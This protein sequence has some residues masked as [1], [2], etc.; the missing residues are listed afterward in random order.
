MAKTKLNVRDMTYVALG[1]ALM[2]IG[3]WITI[4]LAPPL[5]PFTLQ[6]FAVFT[7]LMTLGWRRGTYATLVYILL[8]AVG[9][10]VFAGFRGGIA[11]LFSTTGG[12]I[13]GF[14]A[15]CAVYA[16][17]TGLIKD[18][19]PVRICA[20]VLGLLTC[21]AFGTMWFYIVYLR[22][23]GPVGIGTVLTWCVTPYI[24]PDL[25]KLSLAALLSSRLRKVIR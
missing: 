13:L 23:T 14:F 6:T 11:V 16:V 1:A 18:T 10:P 4:P 22:T 8:G 15:M 2:A 9:V 25:C 3:A 5:V 20:G 19:V 12:Y 17:I 24:I 21:Y 7:V